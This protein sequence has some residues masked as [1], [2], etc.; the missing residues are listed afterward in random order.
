DE[1]GKLEPQQYTAV[2]GLRQRALTCGQ[3]LAALL[4]ARARQRIAQLAASTA[5][6]GPAIVRL[7]VSGPALCSV[8]LL[9]WELLVIDARFPVADEQLHLL[10]ES[11]RDGAADLPEDPPPLSVV[12]HVAAPRAAGLA[13]L[14]LEEAAYRIAMALDPIADRVRFTEMGSVA[15]LTDAVKAVQPVMLH[16]SGHGRPGQLA[17]EDEHGGVHWVPV[18]RLLAELRQ[19]LDRLPLAVWLSCCHSA[20][21]NRAPARNDR[22]GQPV[23]DARS[24]ADEIAVREWGI[25]IERSTSAAADIHLAGIPQVLGYFGPVPDPLAARVDRQLFEALLETGSTLRA[26]Q[27]A[28]MGSVKPLPSGAGHVCF[29]LAWTLLALYHRGADRRLI[30]PGKAL[31]RTVSSALERVPIAL[32]GIQVLEHG[33]IGRRKL[34]AGL[35]TLRQRD[36]ERVLGL[37]GLGGL[38]KTAV[39]VRLASILA[40][41][42]AHWQRRVVA[43]PAAELPDS[44]PPFV[45]LQQ[46]INEVIAR[47]PACPRDWKQTMVAVDQSDDRPAALARALLSVADA[48]P[49]PMVIYVDNA[50]TVQDLAAVAADQRAP[51]CDPAVADFFATL[52][53][54][55]SGS[56]TVLLTTRYRPSRTPGQWEEIPFCSEHEIFRMTAWWPVM[57]RLPRS[58]RAELASRRLQGHARAVEWVNSLLKTQEDRSGVRVSPSEDAAR[59]RTQLIEPALA[60]L[61]PLI[62]GDLALGAVLSRLAPS[63]R[64][65][66]GECTAIHR[67]V[68]YTVIRSLSSQDPSDPDVLRD[69]GLLSRFVS[70]E[71][72][73]AVHPFVVDSVGKDEITWTPS[74]RAVLGRYW[75]E[76]GD[77]V[78]SGG[79]NVDDLIEAMDHLA[80]GLCWSEASDVM[81]QLSRTL[82]NRGQY[83]ARLELLGSSEDWPDEFRARWLRE[84]GSAL[85]DMSRFEL[86]EQAWRDA[87]A[88]AVRLGG[89][90]GENAL[91]VSFSLHGLAN[92]LV[93][94]G[95]YKEAEEAYNECIG[96][97]ERVY[98]TREHAEVAVSLHGLAN[99]L[100][101]QGRYKEAE[102]AYNECI[103]ISERVYKTREHA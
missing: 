98:K 68:P 5:V 88:L 66:L 63:V 10:R 4:P 2:A 1:H 48:S 16:F 73:W 43:I 70:G 85:D 91:E 58:I 65:L 6:D 36:N 8:M 59:V 99:V 87:H 55:A 22:A 46:K 60:G 74:G 24:S 19:S 79:A 11:L 49:E 77:Q 86:A 34:L 14:D 42:G 100:V 32:E 92:V 44:I 83:A 7:R 27:R 53:G 97:S 52:C 39:M 25:E 62:D 84:Y 41:G 76:R 26:V 23:V 80:A 95:R 78:Q 96:I 21:P 67:P 61:P 38:G 57:R 30:E 56:V 72:V 17:F 54:V 75:R 64:A 20:G 33:F 18:D 51:W 101:S 94:Q 69:L 90:S 28:R 93:S 50:E 71:D 37:Y 40:G 3:R 45:W 29:P 47:H 31:P 12:A 13:E 103:G 89:S 15:D 82:R 81:Y 9:P 102:E 35:R